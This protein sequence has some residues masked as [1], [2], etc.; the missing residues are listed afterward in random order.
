MVPAR[1]PGQLQARGDD[2]RYERRE[3]R[4]VRRAAIEQGVNDG[5]K[6]RRGERVGATMPAGITGKKR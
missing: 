6:R 4:V 5:P 2:D 3:A 1:R